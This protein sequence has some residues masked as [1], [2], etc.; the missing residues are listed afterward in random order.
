MINIDVFGGSGG[1]LFFKP[2]SI[3]EVYNDYFAGI[4]AIFWC[5][6]NQFE[7]FCF[8]LQYANHS[9]KLLEWFRNENPSTRLELAVK[10]IYETHFSQGGCNGVIA[11]WKRYEHGFKG[12]SA[13]KLFNYELFNDW[14]DRFERV[15][16]LQEDFVS[17]IHRY[18]AKNVLYFCDPPFT[19]AKKS[20]DRY[21]ELNFSEDDHIRLSNV[22]SSIKGKVIITYNDDPIIREI[23]SN[24]H[25]KEIEVQ[26]T[27]GPKSTYRT[28][29]IIT[30]YPL[31]QQLKLTKFT[32]K[33][34]IEGIS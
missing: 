29:L 1:W 25:I 20:S 28:E 9:A 33:T 32:R 2:K 21:Y 3:M 8:R 13:I 11:R 17:L 30:N 24:F 5:L 26:Y 16:I 10:T 15:Q 23:F 6:T 34:S 12:R 31:A 22:L 7:Q 14:R 19:M 18:D 4:S 27:A